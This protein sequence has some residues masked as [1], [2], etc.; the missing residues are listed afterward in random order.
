MNFAIEI[1]INFFRHEEKVVYP[2]EDMD[3]WERP[4]KE[5][6]SNRGVFY[7]SS[8]IV[9]ITDVDYRHAKRAYR[10]CNNTNLGDYHNLYVQSDVLL[11][12]DLLQNFGNM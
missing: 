9:D 7:S 5:L 11:L 10:E 3:S 6:L 2:Y 12:A 1:L 4:D 8:N